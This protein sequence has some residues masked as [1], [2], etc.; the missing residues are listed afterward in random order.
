ME[1][2]LSEIHHQTGYKHILLNKGVLEDSFHLSDFS[3]KNQKE[4][5]CFLED[6]F[7][8][9]VL[10]RAINIVGSKRKL[11]DK[12][13]V[14]GDVVQGWTGGKFVRGQKRIIP[15]PLYCLFYL[16]E[17]ISEDSKFIESK[18]IGLKC[19]SSNSKIVEAKFPIML[20]YDLGRLVGS[21]LGDGHITGNSTLVYANKDEHLILCLKNLI[22]NLFNADSRIIDGSNQM[23]YLVVSAVVGKVAE[24]FGSPRKN[25]ILAENSGGLD[26]DKIYKATEEFKIGFLSAII[27]DEGCVRDDGRIKL[28]MRLRSVIELCRTTLEDRGIRVSKVFVENSKFF[29]IYFPVNDKI[30]LRS[31]SKSKKLKILLKEKRLRNTQD[32]FAVLKTLQPI[33]TKLMALNMG[34]KEHTVKYHVKKLIKLGCVSVDDNGVLSAGVK[35]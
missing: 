11:A 29:Y 3:T 20:S 13:G 17:I 31:P 14:S 6:T 18:I 19:K 15:I 28:K 21:S 30:I 32:Y 10:E 24:E 27:D 25:K 1:N 34:V 26:L 8:K 4:I 2:I 33:T 35:R 12:L 5:Y 9:D 7:R 22:R 23:K 16:G